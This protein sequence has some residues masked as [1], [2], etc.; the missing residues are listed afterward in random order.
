MRLIGRMGPKCSRL[1]VQNEDEVVAKLAVGWQINA[2]L[3]FNL[4][5]GDMTPNIQIDV[6]LPRILHLVQHTSKDSRIFIEIIYWSTL[7]FDSDET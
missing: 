3:D 7:M 6:F 4:P 5:L 2:H 1:V